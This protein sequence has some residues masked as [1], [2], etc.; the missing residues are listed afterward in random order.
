[1]AQIKNHKKIIRMDTEQ[2][3]GLSAFVERPVPTDEE[4]SSFEKIVE[5]EVKQQ[6]IDSNLDEIYRDK[7]GGLVDVKKLKIKTRSALIVRIFKKLLISFILLAGAYFSYLHFFTGS[8]DMGAVTL[9]IIAPQDIVAGE[10]FSYRIQ[11]ENKTKFT[12]SCLRLELRYPE[13]FIFSSAHPLP[14]RANNS[15]NL[16]DLPAGASG[17]LVV[18]GQIIGKQEVVNILSAR[19]NYTPL[20]FSSEFK[21]EASVSTVINSLG[22]K[23]GLESPSLSFINQ[24]NDVSLTFF[25]L[26][27][28]YLED[29]VIKFTLPDKTTIKVASTTE[30]STDINKLIVTEEST[31]H[32]SVFGLEQETSGQ[33]VDFKYQIKDTISP[34]EMKVSLEKR[35]PD[36]QLYSFWEQVITPELVK[37]DLNLTLTLNNSKNNIPVDFNSSLNYTLAYSN[38]GSDTLKDA[39]IM[40]VLDGSLFDWNSLVL[41][42]AGE[43]RSGSS[44][45]WSHKNNSKL[46][47]IEPGDSGELNFSIKVK[48]YQA[49]YFGQDLSVSAYGQYGVGSEDGSADNKSNLIT[50]K[51][52]SDFILQEKIRYFDDNNIPVGQ[53]P[54]PPKVGELSSFRV[55]WQISNNLHELSQ[56]ETVVNLPSYVNWTNNF[57]VSAGD[58]YYDQANHSVIWSLGRLPLSVARAD[59]YFDISLIPNEADLNKILI[60]STGASSSAIDNDTQ[61]VLKRKTGPK[62]TKL[63]DDDIASLNDSG[64]VE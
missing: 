11:Y 64:R 27:N 42:Q 19:L 49:S 2:E 57:F 1:M 56:V 43:V 55:Y 10:E 12:I 3:S 17:E 51:L 50:S 30:T 41:E 45:I 38:Q 58:L 39:I 47:L 52:N 46:A 4:V 37:S 9:N 5:K 33:K 29:F 8:G 28:N 54:L 13:N 6:E 62:T 16:S 20:N 48:D 31:G 21:K 24:D 59:A 25:D 60:L 36:G 23:V 35:L 61:A 18:T 40:A 22:F 26:E 15:F 32:F 7:K 34:V 14:D 63:E 53:G 44:I